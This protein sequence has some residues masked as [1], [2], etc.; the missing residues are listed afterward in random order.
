MSEA[1]RIIQAALARAAEAAAG[2][3]RSAPA[4]D[5][6][7]RRRLVIGDPQADL[8]QVL[9][10]LAHHG[11]LAR[12]GLLHSD[13]Q[14]VSVG[15]HFD[16]GKPSERESAAASGLAL[17]AWLAAHPANQAVMLL[18]NH[19]LGRVG[20]LA[21]F[22]DARFAEAQAEADRIYPG[23][24]TDDAAEQAYL[25]RWPQVPSAELVARD[26]GNFREAQRAW[27]EHLLRV[28]RFR[29]AHAAASD[30]LVLHAGVTRED[31]DVT[32]LPDA[33]R[34]DAWRVAAALNAA[35]DAAVAAW[36]RGPL[37]IPG[38]HHPG[39]AAQGEGTGIFYQR[40]SLLPE[41]AER[42]RG[43]PRRRFDPR[44][45]P[46][47]LTQVVGHT[48]DKRSRAMLG[49][50]PT[51]AR[52][53]VLRHLVT[54]GTRVDYAHGAPPPPTP[55]AAVLVFT[56]GA[57]RECQAPDYALFDLDTRAAAIAPRPEGR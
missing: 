44:R 20:E 7:W 35:L 2:P 42:V 50:S 43:T 19:D 26:F 14:L 48:R 32:R 1:A 5:G 29:V 31:L 17:V 51:G 25:A 22:T 28:R 24:D 13:V 46:P 33:H 36:T 38:L 9:A 34:A 3:P 27:V 12:D 57:M 49:L 30:V 23:G 18:G 8:A 55:G 15:D 37:V 6:V 56:D 16:W 4:Q 53:G 10:I 41:D 45:L 11:L 39:N 21:G 47:G 40:P 54:D 52:D